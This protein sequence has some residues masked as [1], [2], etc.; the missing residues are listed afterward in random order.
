MPQVRLQACASYD[1]DLVSSAVRACLEGLPALQERLQPGASV[2]L[3]PNIINPCAPERAVCTHPAVVRAVA[4][5][6]CDAGCKVLIAD[7]PGYALVTSPQL[8]F[9]ETGIAQACEGLSVEFDLLKHGGYRT[10]TVPNPLRIEQATIATQALDADLIINLPRCKTHQMTLLTGAI[11]NMFGAVA[12][13]ERIRLHTLGTF[14]AFSEALADTFSACVPH[15]NLM[16]A[17]IGMDGKGPSR[18]DPRP[19]GA[20]LASEDAVALD[21]VAED[22]TG[23]APGEVRTTSAAAQKGLGECD[24]AHISVTGASLSDLRV[25]FQRPPG[26][27]RRGFP[28]WLGRLISGMIWVRPVVDPLL[29]VRCGACAG[30]CPGEAIE[31]EDHAVINYNKCLECFCCQEVCPA[32]AI[33]TKRSWLARKI[34]GPGPEGIGR[35]PEAPQPRDC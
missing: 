16:D 12:P 18:G 11:K 24:L 34:I 30:I 29:C 15:V 33:D 28:G 8:V 13:R 25:S 27:I 4:E 19:I 1:Q 3:K 23:F 9:E 2:L 20:I 35:A 26:G 32:G 5:I 7:E 14:A 6:A 17:V 10:V 22:L 21:A 31:V